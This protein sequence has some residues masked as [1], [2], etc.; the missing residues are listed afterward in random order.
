MRVVITA[1]YD[2]MSQQAVG[3]VSEAI[4]IKPQ[5]VLGVAAGNT[6]RGMYRELIRLYREIRLDFSRVSFLQID[7]YLGL[8]PDHPQSFRSFLW[9]TFF[10]YVNVRRANV[11]IPSELYDETIQRL[12][13]MDFLVSGIGVNGHVAFNEPGSPFD[14]RT[15]LVQLADSTVDLIR[16]NFSEGD[17]PRHGVTM[18]LATIFE[19]RRILMIASGSTKAD[20][21]ARALTGDVT[22]EVPASLLQRHPNLT[23]IADEEASSVYRSLSHVQTD[24]AH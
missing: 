18:G 1:N 4:R 10:N 7:E 15:R 16:P 23:V 12:G 11:Y 24:S 5:L 19:A 14:S 20:I 9:R 13:G 6:P 22:P 21:L 2:E 8:R 3:L 17:L